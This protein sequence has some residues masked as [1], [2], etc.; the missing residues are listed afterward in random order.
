MT[1][2]TLF[3]LRQKNLQNTTKHTC[4]EFNYTKHLKLVILL[5]LTLPDLL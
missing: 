3:K 1:Y 5:E 4:Y 2:Y